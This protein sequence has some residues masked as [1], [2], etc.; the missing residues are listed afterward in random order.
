MFKNIFFICT[1]GICMM[2]TVMISLN[3]LLSGCLYKIQ[4]LSNCYIYNDT[5]LSVLL[6]F[7]INCSCLVSNWLR[8]N[9]MHRF[10]M[11]AF[12]AFMDYLKAK[13]VTWAFGIVL[14]LLGIGTFIFQALN[15]FVFKI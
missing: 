11:L 1:T 9:V 6:C 13:K 7:D 14:V 5:L 10:R 12:L 4:S 2:M 3:M 8:V 15:A